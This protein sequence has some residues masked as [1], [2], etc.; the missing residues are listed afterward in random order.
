VLIG[1]RRNDPIREADAEQHLGKLFPDV[2]VMTVPD[3]SRLIP[4]KEIYKIEAAYQASV[5]EAHQRGLSEGRK[6]GYDQG[7]AD[8]QRDARDVLKRFNA[9]VKDAVDQREEMLEE[10]KH[11]ILDLI[12]KIS[13]KVTFDAISA[14]PEVTSTLIAGVIDRLID[15][16]HIK[17]RVHPD[18]LPLVEQSIDRFLEGSAAIKELSIEADPRV[19]FG[20]C[21]IETP[22]GD[23]DAR[24]DSQFEVVEQAIRSG[25]DE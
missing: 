24:I 13:R 3:G 12:V 6:A 21:F 4:I 2:S 25:E 10:A 18:H 22:T 16:S 11:R 7:L 8:G 14:D 17:I 1:E 20:G 9:A 19:R 15:K 23:I 5:D